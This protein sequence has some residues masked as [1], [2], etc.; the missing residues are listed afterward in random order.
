[1]STT[2]FPERLAES[3][4]GQNV[5]IK[6]GKV[7]GNLSINVVQQEGDGPAF[8]L[9][10]LAEPPV[11]P[12]DS[13]PSV[14]LAARYEVVSFTGRE[15]ERRALAEWLDSAEARAV[16]L[17]T[18]PGGQGKTRLALEVARRAQ[19]DGW[20]VL[21]VRHRLDG[22]VIGPASE[23]HAGRGDAGVLV[24]VDYADRWPHDDLIRLFER[25]E[26]RNVPP[27]QKTRVLLLGRS[28]DFWTTTSGA[29]RDAGVTVSRLPLEALDDRAVGGGERQRV[30]RSAVSSFAA[31]LGVNAS[32]LPQLPSL[33][34]D[35]FALMLSVQ[36][37]A[38]VTVLAARDGLDSAHLSRAA[39]DPAAASRHLISREV[40]HWERM[41]Q[42]HPNPVRVN[43]E[44]IARAVFIATLT[45]GLTYDEAVALLNVLDIG[46]SAPLIVSDH[47]RCYPPP[48]PSRVLEPLYPDRLGEDFLAALLPGAP[49]PPTDSDSLQGLADPATPG[50]LRRMLS[51]SAENTAEHDPTVHSRSLRPVMTVL[52][53][54]A[55]RWPHVAA[56]HVIPAISANP[57][58]VVA[59]GGTA[60]GQ[61]CDVPGA[62]AV[63]PDVGAALERIIGLGVHLDL[64][65]GALRVAERLTDLARSRRD[66]VGLA[67]ALTIVAARRAAVGQWE[68]A[69]AAARE[70]VDI[71]RRLVRDPDRE[72]SIADLPNLATALSNLGKYLP[73]VGLRKESLRVTEEAVGYLRRLADP[74]TGH[75]SIFLPG[76]AASLLNLGWDLHEAAQYQDALVLMREAVD[77]FRQ[78]ANS[79]SANPGGLGDSL[80]NLSLILS[81]LDRHL[82]ALGPAEEAV[83]FFRRLASPD[84]GS[85]D[86]YLPAL[87]MSLNTLSSCL[88]NVGRPDESLAVIQEAAGLYRQLADPVSGSSAAYLPPL[89]GA[90]IN[91]G[92]RL[93]NQARYQEAVEIGHEAVSV[94]R[95]L[96]DSHSGNPTA[97][98]PELALA[99]LNLSGS[100]SELGRH[101][102]AYTAGQEAVAIYRTLADPATGDPDAYLSSLA[103][104]LANFSTDL[105][106]VGRVEE[107]L[108]RVREAVDIFRALAEP[109]S[110]SPRGVNWPELAHCLKSLSIKL[111][112]VGQY[113]E[114]VEPAHEAVEIYRTLADPDYGNPALYLSALGG[115]LNNLGKV[116]TEARRSQEALAATRELAEVY[117]QLAAA[118][119]GNRA[120]HVSSFALVLRVLEEDLSKLGMHQDALA[121][122]QEAVD[123]YRVLADP[124]TGDPDT[125]LP[126]L[127]EAL[128]RLAWLESKADQPAQAL[129]ALQEAIDAYRQLSGRDTDGSDAYLKKLADA[130]G[131]A[132]VCLVE[133]DRK[134]EALAPMGEAVNLY[135]RLSQQDIGAPTSNLDGLAARL[136][137]LSVWL[138]QLGRDVEAFGPVQEAINIRRQLSALGPVASPANLDSLARL[139]TIRSLVLKDRDADSAV[140]SMEQAIAHWTTLT[141]QSPQEYEPILQ[142]A[143]SSLADLLDKADRHEE[144]A[145]VRQR[146]QLE[147]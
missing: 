64:D 132:G 17:V 86:A 89:G 51:L 30:F 147:Q 14:L 57:M 8:G 13:G 97:F 4:S 73:S 9:A 2:G 66:P 35:G 94:F 134:E 36:M 45:R 88:A 117:R 38:L 109:D 50:I 28:A 23:V 75:P 126:R 146:S 129:A 93:R 58:L 120:G 16:R 49:P 5:S 65:S 90:L 22:G 61:L 56:G 119:T 142:V 115:A 128:H 70:D 136:Q 52:I 81:R 26:L 83:G 91:L 84:T 133:L 127:A 114:A 1:V 29:L 144:A 11:I 18:G 55:L 31:R 139:L 42:R 138:H 143:W 95:R 24:L 46:E 106:E 37:A 71:M 63:L 53:E 44:V 77:S 113:S 33:A 43:T 10:M 102:E 19:A 82:E 59:A 76:L 107:G 85:P 137:L 101:R 124:I 103:R 60:V 121:P 130:S 41:M 20:H 108:V 74:V 96:T 62:D 140:E 69:V 3:L 105:A 92:L 34:A 21:I 118:D 116:L 112:T 100:M 12:D 99:L 48:D 80:N 145:E 98:L 141:Q 123:V 87:A 79:G 7:A 15:V 25:P 111:S 104:A 47:R 135:R 54:T 68:E 27:G 40:R 125:Y 39:G 32:Q 131:A 78:L 67:S 6:L 110:G 122:A 72:G